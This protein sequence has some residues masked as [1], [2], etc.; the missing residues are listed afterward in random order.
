MLLLVN[1]RAAEVPAPLLISEQ[2]ACQHE[3][4]RVKRD[5]ASALWKTGRTGCVLA[6]AEASTRVWFFLAL[7][8]GHAAAAYL[9]QRFVFVPPDL[10]KALKANPDARRH[11]GSY[12]ASRRKG[13]LYRLA[14]AKRPE[15]RAK[16]LQEII[17]NMARN[18]SSAERRERAGFRPKPK[19]SRPGKP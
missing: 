9:W 2:D 16:Y 10:V 8:F 19:S 6:E 4:S 13:V 15:T 18:L 11:W 5:N 7:L 14:G 12:S 1:R 3:P 17:E